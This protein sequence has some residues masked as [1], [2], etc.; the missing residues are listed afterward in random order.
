MRG[1]SGQDVT[2]QGVGRFNAGWCWGRS[3]AGNEAGGMTV[4]SRE[5]SNQFGLD[6]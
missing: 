5:V 1:C 4:V 3:Y 6:P 2:G